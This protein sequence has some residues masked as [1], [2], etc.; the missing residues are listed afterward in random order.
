MDEIRFGLYSTAELENMAQQDAAWKANRERQSEAIL[1]ILAEDAEVRPHPEEQG[2]HKDTGKRRYS[3]IPQAALDAEADVMT[4]G[5]TKYGEAN[6]AKGIRWMRLFDS[7]LRHM[8]AWRRRIDI[9]NESALPHLAH[10]RC[11]LGML[12]A[13]TELHPEL[14]DR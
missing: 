9:D 7:A 11:C 13:M 14:D 4:F 6:Y 1:T 2:Q 8:Y 5:A 3:L 10:A 12:L